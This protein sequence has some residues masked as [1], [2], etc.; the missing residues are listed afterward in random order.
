MSAKVF[1]KS[2]RESGHGIYLSLAVRNRIWYV[3]ERIDPYDLNQG[4][5]LCWDGLPDI[6]KRE[7]GWTELR[8]YTSKNDFIIL[9]NAREFVQN[10]I[11]RFVLDAA[12]LFYD[13]LL[14]DKQ[15]YP[16]SLANP[17]K[18]QNELNRIFEDANLPWRMLEGRILKADS[19]WIE[20]EINEKVAELLHINGFQ[21]ALEEFQK[22]RTDLSTGDCKGAIHAANLAFESTMKGMLGVDQEKPGAL[23][24]KLID[25]GIVPEYHEG[26]LKAFEEHILRSVPIAR[27][28]EKGVGHGQGADVSDPPKSL[29]EL[30]INMAGVLILYLMKRH[31]ELHPV[32]AK[33][34][35]EFQESDKEV[36]F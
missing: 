17:E 4:D 14:E 24:R 15:K 31:L 11:A 13:L 1:S 2:H 19:K 22:A 3:I 23:I 29:A 21:G 18:F 34:E 32:Q 8:G 27:N 25:I 35:A 7:H 30:A 33:T 20:E 12:E 26:F 36:P 16:R 6:L 9:N 5:T 10:G 28:L